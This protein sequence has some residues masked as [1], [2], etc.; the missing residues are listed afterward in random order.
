MSESAG[1]H[2]GR[3]C[4]ELSGSGIIVEFIPEMETPLGEKT[5]EDV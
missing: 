1:A 2:L 3:W 5:A 4:L